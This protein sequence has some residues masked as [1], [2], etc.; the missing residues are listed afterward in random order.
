VI[1]TQKNDL[2]EEQFFLT[3]Q[4]ANL[5]EDFVR[6]IEDTSSLFLLYGDKSVGKSWLL[7]ELTSRRFKPGKFHWLDFKNSNASSVVK[8]EA[9]ISSSAQGAP[10]IS[11]LME[12][13]GEGELI[14]VDHFELASNKAQHALFQ[15]WATDGKDKKLNL[16]IA[17]N[18]ESFNE[19]RQLAQQN[20]IEI[21]SFQ[22]LPSS[23]EEVEAFISFLLFPDNPL[24]PLSFTSEV[25]RQIKNCNGVIGNVARVAAQQQDLIT[26]KTEPKPQRKNGLVVGLVL[27]LLVIMVLAY[28]I[29]KPAVQQ[30]LVDN[31]P[32]D[33]SGIALPENE[34]VA[35][36]STKIDELPDSNATDELI[37]S[38]PAI[39][40]PVEQEGSIEQSG[41]LPTDNPIS[42]EQPGTDTADM[43]QL[44]QKPTETD[45]NPVQGLPASIEAEVEQTDQLVSDAPVKG[46]DALLLESANRHSSSFQQD[47][48]NTLNW[49]MQ[50]DKDRA[51]IQIM[52]L[53]LSEFTDDNYYKSLDKMKKQGVDVSLI[54]IYPT[55]IKDRV[56]YGVIYGDYDNREEAREQIQQLPEGVKSNSPVTRT[57]NG[58]WKDI[59]GK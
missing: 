57:M 54:K 31:T 24:K 44:S 59:I 22:L 53:G 43:V 26:Q 3:R 35:T 20:H 47:L 16:I 21:K 39:P 27:G 19:V 11:N 8:A 58:I 17:A 49:L 41:P 28:W 13:V 1:P 12:K 5:M 52:S 46:Y 32:P 55:R 18:S 56:L 42:D 37:V 48:K 9:T 50:I 10:D 29:L 15:S 25:S 23:R 34:L 45:D 30:K 4:T 14:I 51:T 2:T 33:T 38:G 40:E 36:N 7:R 6:E